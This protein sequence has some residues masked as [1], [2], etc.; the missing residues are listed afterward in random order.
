[1]LAIRAKETTN[2]MR[3]MTNPK[4]RGHVAR[5]DCEEEIL[6]RVAAGESLL[7]VCQDDHMPPYRTAMTWRQRYADFAQK[8]DEAYEWGQWAQVDAMHSIARGGAFS[9]GDVQRD[10]LLI[11][12][13]KWKASKINYRRFGD[14]VDVKVDTTGYTIAANPAVTAMLSAP[15]IIDAEYADAPL[16]I[17]SDIDSADDV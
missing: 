13:M 16:Q 9:S 12:A 1:M 5:E 10:R 2:M 17:D 15:P 3:D 7:E 4:G 11:D 14:R 6:S 8:L